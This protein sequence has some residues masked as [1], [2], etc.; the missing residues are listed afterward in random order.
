[1]SKEYKPLKKNG[2]IELL[3]AVFCLSILLFHISLDNYGIDWRPESWGGVLRYGALG[4]EFFF[5][6]S[7]YFM[8][9][10][11]QNKPVKHDEIGMATWQF[12]WRKVKTLLPY[13][14]AFN[15]AA[16]GIGLFRGHSIVE[17]INRFSCLF[18][19]PTMGFNDGEWML[20]AEWYIGFML[21]AMLIIFILHCLVDDHFLMKIIAP[22][23]TVVIY[24]Y[25]ASNAEILISGNH[26]LRAFGG[27][28]LGFT[29]YGLTPKVKEMT[30]KMKNGF[31]IGLIRFYPVLIIVLFVTYFNTNIGTDA[32]PF[33]VLILASGLIFTFAEE[34]LVSHSHVLDNNIVYWLGSMSLP[35]YMVQNITRMV[36]QTVL[37]GR[38]VYL[39]FATELI[40]TIIA[41]IGSYYCWGLVRKRFQFFH[42]ESI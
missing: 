37:E 13:H 15:L 34:G 19:L 38:P 24:G 42:K 27:I 4:V 26:M 25:I 14:I 21:F 6:T 36:G 2:T 30:S 9:K 39:V 17:N 12:M 22:I 7:G 20:G 10:S 8:A 40:L 41:G 28:L 11:I 16:F 23:G 1:M 5:I 18:F 3:R 35:I 29:L 31:V 32:Q 33:M